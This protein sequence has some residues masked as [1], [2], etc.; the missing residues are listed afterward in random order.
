MQIFAKGNLEEY[1]SHMQ[2]VLCLIS[3][4]GLDAQCK[5][6]MKERNEQTTVLEA[7]SPASQVYWAPGFEFR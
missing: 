1:L 6:L 2:A 3:Y 4:K 5:K 7:R